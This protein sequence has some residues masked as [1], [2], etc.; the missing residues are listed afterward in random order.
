[1]SGRWSYSI[2]A[3]V[4]ATVAP[5]CSTAG[6]SAVARAAPSCTTQW[7]FDGYTELRG[8]NG[9]TLTFDSSDPPMHGRATEYRDGRI[10]GGDLWASPNHFDVGHFRAS[11]TREGISWFPTGTGGVFFGEDFDGGVDANGFAYGTQVETIYVANSN[12]NPPPR[13]SSTYITSWRSASPLKCAEAPPPKPPANVLT[14]EEGT[15]LPLLNTPLNPHALPPEALAPVD[16]PS[17]S[18]CPAPECDRFG[19]G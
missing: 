19:T 10:M 13:L 14:P 15:P 17:I 1:M 2:A 8:D 7:R 16:D 4:L 5:T 6:L 3:I 18:A 9:G 12:Q 11:F